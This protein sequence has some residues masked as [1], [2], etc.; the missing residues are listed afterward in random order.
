[1]TQPQPSLLRPEGHSVVYR[2]MRFPFEQGFPR[3]WHSDSA[4]K[5]LFWDQLSTAFEPGERFFIDSARALKDVIADPKLLQELQDFCKQEG[6]HTA[7]HLKLDRMNAAYGIDVEGCSRRYAKALDRT[8]TRLDPLGQLAVTVALEH[9]TAC[10]AE[11]HFDRP[12][13]SEGADPGVLALWNWH[14]AEE[15]EHKG[16][17]YDIYKAAGGGY[18]RRVTIMPSAWLLILGLSVI[19]TFVLLHKDKRLFTRDTLRGVRYLFGR[20]GFFTAL[21]P[22]FLAFFKPSFHP[23]KKNDMPRIEKWAA[24]NAQYVQA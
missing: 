17:C 4:F 3:Y 2:R 1:M 16:T 19:N 23:W 15:L 11:V 9:F 24:D 12:D 21:W 10:C 8:R 22:S 5:T 20:R 7:Q 13:H 14:A 6:H 18:L